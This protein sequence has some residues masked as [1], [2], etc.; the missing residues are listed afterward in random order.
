MRVLLTLTFLMACIMPLICA[1]STAT[2][3]V[4][5]TTYPGP[6]EMFSTHFVGVKLSSG[7][8]AVVTFVG[9]DDAWC[10][11]VLSY[12]DHYQG[13]PFCPT[14]S[15]NVYITATGTYWVYLAEDG[16]SNNIDWIEIRVVANSFSGTIS[17]LYSN[18]APTG[19]QYGYPPYGVPM[20]RGENPSPPPSQS[21]P[22]AVKTWLIPLLIVIIVAAIAIPSTIYLVRRRNA[23]KLA[24]LT[25]ATTEV[26]V[27]KEQQQQQDMNIQMTEVRV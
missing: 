6:W 2:V 13:A 18:Y 21:A 7:G 3:Y 27:M 24:A 11:Y 16:T 23:K 9:G 4:Q 12:S 10:Q 22:I 19:W 1:Q 8:S 26:D 20:I 5:D 17:S 15:Q 14:D 25:T